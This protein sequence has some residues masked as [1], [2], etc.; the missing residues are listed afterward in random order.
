MAS[1][2]EYDRLYYARN[3][4]K[5]IEQRRRHRTLH[6]EEAQAY[7]RARSTPER[8]EKTEQ[9]R[10]NNLERSRGH[11]QAYKARKKNLFVENVDPRTVFDR[12]SGV[13]QICHKPIG[14]AKWHIDHVIPLALGGPHEYANTQLSHA[15]CNLKKH[16]RLNY[17]VV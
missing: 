8:R 3:R 9:W 16:T 13:C 14:D 1:R 11:K 6:L 2:K 4:E 10:K 5:R 15:T 17:V 7:D 12:N